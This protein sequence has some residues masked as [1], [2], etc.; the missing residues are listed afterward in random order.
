ML[1]A[2]GKPL[3]E[4]FEVERIDH[5]KACALDGACTNWAKGIFRRL[6]GA[7]IGIHPHPAGAYRLRYA[8]ASSQREDHDGVNN[9]D[10][11][12]LRQPRRST[13]DGFEVI[14]AN[15]FSRLV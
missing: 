9:G 3:H 11:G 12:G 6:R 10:P 14:G 5:Q 13:S 4:H 8:Q 15:G 2:D 1:H 7:E